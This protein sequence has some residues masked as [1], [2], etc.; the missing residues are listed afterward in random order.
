MTWATTRRASHVGFVV[1]AIVNNLAPLLF[2]VL[3]QAYGID[4]AR[5]GLLASLN[6]A[7]QLLTDLVAIGVI[8]RVGYRRAIVAGHACSALGLIALAV[9][10]LVL[11]SPFVGLCLAISVYAV[12]GGLLEVV[13]SPI[14][15]HIPE[16]D[17]SK[18]AG[19]ALLHSFYCWGQ[20]G[21]VL[22]TTGLLAVIGEGRW[23]MLPLLWAIVPV[24]N[25]L[26]L[27]RAPMPPAI[28]DGER[29]PLRELGASGVFLALLALMAMGGAS[30]LTMSQW[31][32]F[33]AQ[34]ATGMPKQVGDLL[35]P[36]LFALLMGLGRMWHATLG[37]SVDLRRLLIASGLGAA[38]CYL[39]C[40]VSSAPVASLLAC[41][42]C[43]VFVALMW[44]GTFSLTAARFPTGGAAMFAVLALAGDTGATLGPSGAGVISEAAAVTFAPVSALLPDD[45]G[46]GLRT[47]VLLSALVPLL[48][49]VVVAS[50]GR[51]RAQTEGRPRAN[52]GV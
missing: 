45:G 4:V 12:G 15:E 40:A 50:L 5:L 52:A 20:L 39:I 1:Q 48:F 17:R 24:V 34:S 27:L 28:P 49:A 38:V 8:D 16:S 31:S 51:G 13:V 14:V 6:F 30:E 19:M 2:I 32:S 44:P 35:G 42:G 3:H 25:G 41:A 11:A 23:W 36:G 43:G 33:F 22:V 9:L 7:V 18:A 29:T 21:V 10:P 47:G 46:T 26:I 37:A